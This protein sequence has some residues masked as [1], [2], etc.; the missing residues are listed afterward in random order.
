MAAGTYETGPADPSLPGLLRRVKSLA[1]SY[2]SLV[3]VDAR[4]AVHQIIEVL[5]VAIVA[6]VLVVTAWLAFVVAVAGWLVADGVSWPGVL[7]C[8]GL[9]NVVAAAVAG[10]WLWRQLKHN[11][12]LAATLRQVEGEPARGDIP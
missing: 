10:L 12:P 7:A 4:H 5:C 3:V 11:P 2:A 6:A 1:K 8:A 9:I